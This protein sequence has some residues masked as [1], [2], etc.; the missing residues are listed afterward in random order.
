MVEK[1]REEF[2]SHLC[3]R[4]CAMML[5]HLKIGSFSGTWFIP[6]SIVTKLTK[7][8]S[9]V[10]LMRHNVKRLEIGETCVYDSEDHKVIILPKNI[11]SYSGN[12]ELWFLWH[13]HIDFS[14]SICIFF[15]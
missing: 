10:L 1:F 9:Q 12:F 5:V 7:C 3:L 2:A 15:V 14:I 8:I 6:E 11:I 13:V 4:E